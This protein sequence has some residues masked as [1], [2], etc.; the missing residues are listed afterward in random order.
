MLGFGIQGSSQMFESV[1]IVLQAL[2][3]ANA[4]KKLDALSYTFV[5]MPFSF[6][7]LAAG[8][9]ANNYTDFVNIPSPTLA[10][11]QLW[12]PVLV[13][14]LLLA[15][16]LNLVVAFF[17]QHTAA[18]A[19]VLAGIVKDAAI[20]IAGCIAFGE[21]MSQL[22]VVGFA[23]QLGTITLWGM[24]KL[25]TKDFEDG[26]AVGFQRV[27]LRGLASWWGKATGLDES[28]ILVRLEQWRMS[29]NICAAKKPLGGLSYGALPTEEAENEGE[30]VK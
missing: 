7:L 10:D 12:G 25:F 22:Q 13:A 17:V 28:L 14:N 18:V 4:G 21:S 23:I 15:F 1:R 9:A 11:L 3:L 29:N 5:T 30:K 19:C 24:M 26:F 8:V 27:L 20:V 6:V 2:L 16:S